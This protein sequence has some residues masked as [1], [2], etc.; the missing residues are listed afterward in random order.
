MPQLKSY[1]AKYGESEATYIVFAIKSQGK[2]ATQKKKKKEKSADVDVNCYS[3]FN[4]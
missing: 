1:L 4:F 3:A 2:V